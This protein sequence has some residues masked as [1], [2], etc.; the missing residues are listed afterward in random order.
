MHIKQFEAP[1]MVEAVRRVKEELGP[2]ALI[3][4][5]RTV[6]RSHGIFGLF[7]RP[8]ALVTAAVER[9][10]E[11]PGE[12]EGRP[13][14]ERTGEAGRV[15]ELSAASA[16]TG[17]AGD[18]AGRTRRVPDGSQQD[19]RDA[20]GLIAALEGEVRSLRESIERMRAPSADSEAAFRELAQLRAIA[21]ELASRRQGLPDDPTEA[22][23]IARLLAAGIAT[24]HAIRLVHEA[25]ASDHER[26]D[27]ALEASLARALDPRLA[28]PRPDRDAHA[29]ELFVG[30]TG[31]GK[32]TTLAK[33]AARAEHEGGGVSLMTTDT[34][35]IGAEAQLRTYA[36]LIGVP[37]EVAGSP[38]D[39]SSR[40][41][42]HPGRRT[43]IDSAGRGRDEGAIAELARYRA[44]LGPR[45]RVHL[46]LSATTKDEELRSELARYRPLAPDSLV[47]TK[48]DECD[49]LGNVANLLLDEATPPL[50]WTTH[51][52]RVPEDLEL[53]QPATLARTLARSAA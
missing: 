30:P 4:R 10:S 29:L 21:G 37:F 13:G 1:T 20:R 3:L 27:E 12:R 15:G 41:R 52:Q 7:A 35:R 38:S 14:T 45:A 24:R 36:E 31:V 18:A 6:R 33:L 22:R 40:L 17:D 2:D 26:P 48:L 9:V 44:A 43:L 25:V 23:L 42:H 16:E 51:G 39:L 32:T 34:F 8:Q 46:V 50:A 53:P 47:M 5:T 49:T 19:L 11:T 28:V